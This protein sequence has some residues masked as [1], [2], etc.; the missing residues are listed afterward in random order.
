MPLMIPSLLTL[1]T[2]APVNGRPL[3]FC[4]SMLTRKPSAVFVG[5]GKGAVTCCGGR[6]LGV[7]VGVAE[8]DASVVLAT[9]MLRTTRTNA[10]AR[11]ADDARYF[12]GAASSGLL[13]RPASWRL[14]ADDFQK[15]RFASHAHWRPA[16]HNDGLARCDDFSCEQVGFDDRDQFV[17]RS[18]ERHQTRDDA[19]IQRKPA[20]DDVV[21]RISI[22]RYFRPIL[23]DD[24]RRKTAPRERR[25]AADIDAFGD[26]ARR[27]RDRM[28]VAVDAHAAPHAWREEL[29]GLECDAHHRLDGFERKLAGCGL[30]RQHGRV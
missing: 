28:R 10:S 9:T 18:P 29:L 30:F 1:N 2:S 12:M 25:D 17:S 4:S 6:C 13:S 11:L 5:T 7:A 20:R 23:A 16:D 27:V 15:I 3:P 24:A 8:V 14:W 22:D 26:A 21:R 19:P